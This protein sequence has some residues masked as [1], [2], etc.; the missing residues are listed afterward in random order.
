MIFKAVVNTSSKIVGHRLFNRVVIA[1]IVL[2]AILLGIETNSNWMAAYG[3]EIKTLDFLILILF[4]L[5]ILLKIVA[6][7]KRPH[8]YFKDGWNVMDFLIVTACFLPS[9]SN[10]MAVFRLVRVLRVLRLLTAFPKLQA[11]V[12]GLLKSVPSIGYVV[13]L[14]ALHLYMFGVLGV[15]LFAKNDPVHFGSLGTT[16]LSLFQ[17]L[18]LE[19]WADIMRTQMYGCSV[20]GYDNI[21]D[22]CTNSIP[23]PITAMLYFVSFILVGTMIFLNLLIGVVVNSMAESHAEI[24]P[25]AKTPDVQT[26]L[27]DLQNEIRLLRNEIHE[28]KTSVISKR[29]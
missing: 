21:K 10:A 3:R 22:L 17:T 16:F 2:S 6:Q 9:G 24:E 13:A 5:E 26:S 7:G 29:N 14:L 23:Q 8:H 18:T 4:S 1:A 25:T 15:F 28:V 12:S 20:W 11:I 27:V 19:G